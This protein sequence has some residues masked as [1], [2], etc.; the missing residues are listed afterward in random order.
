MADMALP[1]GATLVDS[2][3]RLPPGAELVDKDA[4]APKDLHQQANEAIQG[5]GRGLASKLNPVEKL[6]GVADMLSSVYNDPAGTA[7]NFAKEVLAHPYVAF[8]RGVEAAKAGKAEEAMAH[9]ANALEPAGFVTEPSEVK[10]ATPG[11]RS[12]GYGEMT[13]MG[14]DA[15]ISAKAPEA[16][17]KAVDKAK[18]LAT[19]PSVL[20]GV[21]TVV[22]AK[23]GGPVGA[24]LGREMASDLA[25]SLNP[26]PATPPPLRAEA[27][28]PPLP[29]ANP[30]LDKIAQGMGGK[31]FEALP[32]EG[33][34]TVR[35]IAD[36]LAGN[37]PAAAKPATSTAP[38]E[39]RT[40]EEI[41]AAEKAATAPAAT[42]PAPV[43]PEPAPDLTTKLNN[44][45]REWAIKMGDDPNLPLGEFK[46]GHY[47]VRFAG[48][49]SPVINSGLR[50]AGSTAEVA[51]PEKLVS[52]TKFMD[53]LPDNSPLLGNPKALQAAY[54]LALELK[55]TSSKVG[56]GDLMKQGRQ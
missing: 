3:M 5:F 15:L 42:A 17:S 11:Q 28:P 32:P 30:M 23:V 56:I 7:V 37:A 9:F 51:N 21:G 44:L 16:L 19:R 40:P 54:K 13:G 24:I 47:P 55:K 35:G 50:K 8:A 43:T 29:P 53:S 31:S 34:A 14:L 49:D 18:G 2:G 1:P 22:G 46:H 39:W 25:D 45:K 33:Q 36:K 48:D 12:E 38:V 20:R 41:A 27:T 26:P 4:A 6:H 10:M 52:I